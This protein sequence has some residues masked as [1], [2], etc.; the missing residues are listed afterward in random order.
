MR[1][2]CE[3]IWRT[4]FPVPGGH[5]WTGARSR[6]EITGRIPTGS[7][8]RN[9]V[10]VPCEIFQITNNQQPSINID[11]LVSTNK[12]EDTTITEWSELWTRNIQTT[13]RPETV[14]FHREYHAVED[15]IL[16]DYMLHV[17][18]TKKRVSYQPENTNFISMVPMLCS[19]SC[20]CLMLTDINWIEMNWIEELNTNQTPIMEVCVFFTNSTNKL[21]LLDTQ[22]LTGISGIRCV[23]LQSRSRRRRMVRHFLSNKNL[24]SI[25][26]PSWSEW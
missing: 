17:V 23:F 26:Y 18:E 2:F 25:K 5:I 4:R 6:V 11:C 15:V 19:L 8:C 9:R 14:D 22:G 7:V 16:V 3:Q 24:T 20:C 13:A 21:I 10:H 1:A 12:Y